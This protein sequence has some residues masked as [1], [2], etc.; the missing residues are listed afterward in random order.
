MVSGISQRSLYLARDRTGKKPLYYGWCGSVFLFASEL[1]A[2][3]VHPGFHAEIDRDA[4]TQY[5]RFNYIPTPYSIYRG[6]SK[7]RPGHWV[8][9][10]HPEPGVLPDPK[11]YW[12]AKLVAEHA[13]A[14]RFPGNQEEAADELD[15]LL[16][17]A[18]KNRMYADVPI[19]A[20]LSGGIDSSLIVSLMQAQSTRP[21]RTFTIGYADQEFNEAPYARKVAQHIGTE[22]TEYTVT[23]EDVTPLIPRLPYVYDEPFADSSQ[24]PSMLVSELARRSV[25]VVLTGDGADELFGGYHRHFRRTW[26]QIRC[27]PLP[28]RRLLAR[29]GHALSRAAWP[30]VE[31]RGGNGPARRF[32]FGDKCYKLAAVLPAATLEEFYLR[33]LSHWQHPAELVLDSKEVPTTA[34]VRAEWADL[35][36][37]AER[38]MFLDTITYLPDD[39]LTKVDRAT[40]SVALEARAPFLDPTVIAFAWR[41]PLSM[42]IAGGQGKSI[43]R[44]MLLKYVPSELTDRRK[45]GFGIPIQTLLRGPLR[46]WA[47]SLVYS[48]KLDQDGI[49]NPEPVRKK[50]Q[51]FLRNGEWQYALWGFLMLQAWLERRRPVPSSVIGAGSAES[52]LERRTGTGPS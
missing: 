31:L 37:S 27:I 17:A 42:K 14:T 35:P 20:F 44:S 2:L 43:L 19:G 11:P 39:I 3:E 52:V 29:Y 47:E 10:Y 50:W 38:M 48:R 33:H 46:E 4:L 1:K 51:D 41:L 26:Q 25:T 8:K 16:R 30:T 45:W 12:S 7:L 6:I 34:T 18:V 21:V 40:M 24:I 49:V 9:L 36:S 32:A 5:F 13:A 23:L 28:V 15:V 22:H